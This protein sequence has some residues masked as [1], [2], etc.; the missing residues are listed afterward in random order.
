MT[1]IAGNPTPIECARDYV[2]S[3]WARLTKTL[4]IDASGTRAQSPA[5]SLSSFCMLA[6]V[7]FIFF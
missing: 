6:A 5:S 2:P 3:Y 1:I 7:L 4:R